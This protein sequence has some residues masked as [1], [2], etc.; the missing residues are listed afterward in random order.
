VFPISLPKHKYHINLDGNP[1]I[2][3]CS[4][5]REAQDFYWVEYIDFCF[6]NTNR[7]QAAFSDN[8]P[9]HNVPNVKH[10]R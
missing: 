7:L 8:Q 5:K 1:Q 9:A 6:A 4:T 2:E 3:L 10:Y